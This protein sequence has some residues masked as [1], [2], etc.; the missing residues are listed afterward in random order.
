MGGRGSGPL[1]PA[2]PLGGSVTRSWV[3]AV[4]RAWTRDH[5]RR[6]RGSSLGFVC[7][8]AAPVTTL[9]GRPG[10]ILDA[11]V[12]VVPAL[13]AAAG[14][15][16]RAPGLA[17]QAPSRCVEGRRAAPR[18][19]LLRRLRVQFLRRNRS[20]RP[21]TLRV[22]PAHRRERMRGAAGAINCGRIARGNAPGRAPP[23]AVHR[24]THLDRQ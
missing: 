21:P 5:R 14:A 19:R 13:L 8:L 18:R 20:S 24:P 2:A 16:L 22:R 10:S 9:F 4:C 23:P 15:W 1:T 7:L 3:A 12:P 17:R 6:G 11:D